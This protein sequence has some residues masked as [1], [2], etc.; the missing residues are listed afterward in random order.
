MKNE[1]CEICGKE[2]KYN[3]CYHYDKIQKKRVWF[4]DMPHHIEWIQTP[5]DQ[6]NE[7]WVKNYTDMGE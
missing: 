7:N 1:R 4:C 6:N 3:W 2:V 5:E